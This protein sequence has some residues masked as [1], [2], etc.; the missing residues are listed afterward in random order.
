MMTPAV[1]APAAA[2]RVRIDVPAGPLGDAVLTLGRQAGMTIG[3]TDPGLAAL[4]SPGAA[5]TMAVAQALRA[6][7]RGLPARAVAVDPFSWRII[8]TASPVATR[9]APRPPPPAAALPDIV[10]TGTK[11]DTL[12]ADYPGTAYM[13]DDA[14]E[15][16]LGGAAGLRGTDAIVARLPT[17]GST[18]LGAGRNKLFIRGVADSSFNG[19]SQATVGQYF[20]DLRLNYN[21]PD[22]ALELLDMRAVEVLEGPQGTLYGAGSLGGIFRLVP[23]EPVLDDASGEFAAGHAFARRGAEGGDMAGLANLPLVRGSVAIRA[24]AYRTVDGGYIDDI[25]R[26]LTDINRTVTKGARVAVRIAPGDGWTIDLIGVD[27]GIDAADGQYAERGLPP[28]SRASTIAQPFDNDYALAGVTLAKDFGGMRFSSTS[29]IVAHDVTSRYDFTPAGG[30]PTLFEQANRIRLLSS[31]NRL[32][33]RDVDGAGWVVGL[34]LLHDEERLSRSLGPVAAPV[35]ILG[36][37]NVASEVS[38]Y[39]EGGIRLWPEVTATAGARI[40]YARLVGRPTDDQ[41]AQADQPRRT[42]VS[43][44][45]S[46]AISWRP[47][48]AA[49]LYARYHEG[50]R[51]GGLSVSAA[52]GPVTAQ[53]FRGD[54]LTTLES[55]ARLRGIAGGTVDLSAAGSYAHW[56]HIQADLVD[57]VGLPFTANIGSGRIFGFEALAGWRPI[58]RLRLEAALFVNKSRLTSATDMLAAAQGAALPN[59]PKIGARAS[60]DGKLPLRGTWTVSGSA[61][62]RYAG[63]SRLGVGSTLAIEQGRYFDSAANLRL[64]TSR[65]GFT[66]DATNLFDEIGNR[67]ALGNPFDVAAGRQVVPLR[68]RTVRIGF[69]VGF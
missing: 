17:I 1:A 65:Y 9:V 7:L 35:R 44:L 61:S 68:P 10:V 55:G 19:P 14:P 34:S 36:V 33:Q 28:L 2:A 39:G 20:G 53:R 31:E 13:L 8:G 40:D 67:F 25:G 32:S 18:A 42:E 6:L 50:F 46:V 49:T 45:P 3:L 56:E 15:H 27:Q 54:S 38:G 60:I 58:R 23:Q 47:S 62:L 41:L 11:R 51:P 24:V 59:V 29:G 52:G 16:E 63:A 5:G 64:G 57:S 22:P 12:L 43:V 66:L 69:D 37:G 30:A 48:P 4:R 21:A 26:G